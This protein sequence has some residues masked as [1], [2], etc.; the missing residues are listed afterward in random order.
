MAT[1]SLVTRGAHRCRVRI[2]HGVLEQLPDVWSPEWEE[3]VVIG[4][5]TVL[6]LFRE[7]VIGLVEPLVN[8]MRVLDFKPGEPNKSRRTKERLE[9]AMLEDGFGRKTCVLAVGGGISLDLAGLVAATYMRGIPYIN[10]PTTLLAQ[11]DASI[12]GKTAVNTLQGKNLVGAFHQPEVVLID[13]DL[14][15][16]LPVGEWRNGLAEAVKHAVIADASLFEWMESN[17]EMLSRPSG[18]D[19]RLLKRCVDIKADVVG[20]DEKE[21][22]RRAILNYGHT[23]AH[24]IEKATSY[25]ISHGAAVAIGM[26]VE[27]DIAR[28]RTGFPQHAFQRLSKLLYDLG[29]V[30][31]CQLSR[32]SFEQM[33]PYFK[34]D[35]KRGRQ[36]RMSLPAELGRMATGE[37]YHTLPVEPEEI[38]KAWDENLRQFG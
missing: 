12:G 27:A 25:R 26:L 4:D 9:D 17:T 15:A 16:T 3:S 24:A 19:T 22:G 8:R 1:L 23:I 33:E 32:L 7:R 35:K 36:I 10:I 5:C 37:T 13:P 20:E 29:L 6:G 38:R 34:C 2:G 11:V 18:I 28:Q 21:T 31:G 30:S 14:L